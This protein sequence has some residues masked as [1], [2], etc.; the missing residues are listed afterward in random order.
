[1]DFYCPEENL[2][3]ELDGLPHFTEDGAEYDKKRTEYL[4][5]LGITELRFENA[6][7]FE[8]TKQVIEKIRS[9]FRK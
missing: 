8:C 1:M 3:I 7:V 4:N 5:A 2:T 6:E 9:C